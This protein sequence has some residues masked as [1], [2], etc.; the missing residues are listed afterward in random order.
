MAEF[1]LA[2]GTEFQ[3]LPPNLSW[4]DLGK[5]K[6]TSLKT[7]TSHFN[8]TRLP[9]AGHTAYPAHNMVLSGAYVT[10]KRAKGY[11]RRNLAVIV[12]SLVIQRCQCGP[13][14]TWVKQPWDPNEVPFLYQRNP[15]TLLTGLHPGTPYKSLEPKKCIGR[16]PQGLI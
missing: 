5:H 12:M 11:I 15:F 9:R 16:W 10:N 7:E 6:E 1:L 3:K 2:Q 4:R 13:C 8:S 14:P